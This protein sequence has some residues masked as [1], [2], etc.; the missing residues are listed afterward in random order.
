MAKPARPEQ[1]TGVSSTMGARL[2][3]RRTELDLTLTEAARRA[4]VS[5]SYLAAVEGG[6]S[7]P[8]LPVLSRIA[9]ALDITIYPCQ[10]SNI[11]LEF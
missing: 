1:A 9:H 7:T 11:A 6:S 4:E 5:T 2:R 10:P 3:T 8:S